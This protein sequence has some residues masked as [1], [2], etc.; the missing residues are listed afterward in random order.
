MMMGMEETEM[1]EDNTCNSER[2]ERPKTQESVGPK[3]ITFLKPHRGQV[4]ESQVCEKLEKDAEQNNAAKDIFTTYDMG[5]WYL[6]KWAENHHPVVGIQ[7]DMCTH[8][9]KTK[10]I[11]WK[12]V[13][14]IYEGCQCLTNIS[15]RAVPSPTGKCYKYAEGNI[16]SGAVPSLTGGYYNCAEG[17]LSR[18]R[19]WGGK[20]TSFGPVRNISTGGRGVE[21]P[22]PSRRIIRRG[23]RRIVNMSVNMNM[24][25]ERAE[26]IGNEHLHL[27]KDNQNQSPAAGRKAK[28]WK[29]KG[30]RRG[31]VKDGLVQSRLENFVR[32]Y[33]NLS[34]RG[35][36][37]VSNG[38]SSE[39]GNIGSAIRRG[40][41]RVSSDL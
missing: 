19:K 12:S 8:P 37:S 2:M 35:G 24:N 39:G 38:E 7:D 30:R 28:P 18:K 31:V 9:V 26:S 36:G 32:S 5:T 20:Y 3:C 17:Y 23:G 16:S 40:V 41:K 10:H 27:S 6:T 11:V 21:I 1:M 22:P 34:I 14:A 25:M 4:G 29:A 33:P 15:S 13:C